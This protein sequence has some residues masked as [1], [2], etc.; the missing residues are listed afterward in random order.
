MF[1]LNFFL[2]KSKL[3]I[4]KFNKMF[5]KSL[6]L[7]FFVPFLTEAQ[8]VSPTE[9]YPNILDL[10]E[11]YFS[12][13]LYWK[14]DDIEI[15]F[16]LHFKKSQWVLFGFK[17]ENFSD[18]IL[19]WVF[20]DGI[21]HFS[22]RNMLPNNS[23]EYDTNTNWFPLEA[24]TQNDTTVIKFKRNIKICDNQALKEDLDIETGSMNVLFA[25][26]DQIDRKNDSIQLNNINEIKIDLLVQT[27]GPFVCLRRPDEPVLNS[28]PTANYQYELDLIAGFYKIYWNYTDIDVV[29]EVHCKTDGWVGFGFSPN[30]GM[31]G[32]DVVVGWI[33]NGQVNFTD[34]HIVGRQVL[35]DKNQDWKLL[36]SS[37]SNGINVF[38]FMRKIK[39]CDPDD[40]TIEQGSPYIIFAYGNNDPLLDKDINYHGMNRGGKVVSFISSTPVKDDFVP[41]DMEILDATIS[42]VVLPKDDTFYYCKGFE[43][44]KEFTQKRHIYKVTNFN[45]KK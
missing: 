38:K 2:N 12:N 25:L 21:G 15:T 37:E 14:H 5:K 35:I 34:R 30:G 8:S 28:K 24:F 41:D 22:D 43:V 45:F 19:S 36:Y 27:N 4:F 44:P 7:I 16:E 9:N 6:I 11:D 10:P 18:V 40:L 31:D 29:I 17:S 33:S 13:R 39:L 20:S 26:G 3:F 23:L 32:S 42:N 1:Y